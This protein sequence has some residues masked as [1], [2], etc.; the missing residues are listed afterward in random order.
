MPAASLAEYRLGRSVS[1]SEGVSRLDVH[2]NLA[3][4]DKT[5]YFNVLYPLP[6]PISPSQNSR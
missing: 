4:S 5:Y 1:I 6:H 2:S 3:F